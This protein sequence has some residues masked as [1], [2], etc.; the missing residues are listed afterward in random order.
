MIQ[1][2]H[3]IKKTDNG[4]EVDYSEAPVI[5]RDQPTKKD[6]AI[7]VD[8]GLKLVPVKIRYEG[9]FTEDQVRQ[10]ITTID[11][12]GCK[13]CESSE[14]TVAKFFNMYLDKEGIQ[15]LGA[16]DNSVVESESL[17]GFRE[18]ILDRKRFLGDGGGIVDG[19]LNRGSVEN[20][21]NNKP[22]QKGFFS[23]A[24]LRKYRPKIRDV[25]RILG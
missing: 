6:P 20:N 1:N 24:E 9:D 13:L 8:M 14:K 5:I 19:L 2:K 23:L 11:K 17:F 25:F 15:P 4:W 10:G 7:K 21:P 3:Q 18:R 22:E 12:M 16:V